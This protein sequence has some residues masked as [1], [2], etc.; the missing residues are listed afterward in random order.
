MEAT[1]INVF[2]NSDQQKRGVWGWSWVILAIAVVYFATARL[3]LLLSVAPSEASG[4][5]PPA[6]I[7]AGAVIIYG[8]RAAAGVFLGAVATY[9][10]SWLD[11]GSVTATIRSVDLVILLSVAVTLQCLVISELVNKYT[12]F[13]AEI[14]SERSTLKFA[15]ILA[16][17]GCLIASTLTNYIF[18]LFDV[19]DIS[20][21]AFSFL[22]WWIGDTIGVV[23]MVP[24]MLAT[25]G[26]RANKYSRQLP[27]AF[28]M[29]LVLSAVF[30][31]F[32]LNQKREERHA[33]QVFQSSVNAMQFELESSFEKS[34]D[35]VHAL[36]SF[37]ASSEFVSDSDFLA[38][39]DHFLD[40]NLHIQ[41]L[42]WIPRVLHEER[43]LFEQFAGGPGGITQLMGDNQLVYATD[44]PVYFPVRYVNPLA[45]N[46]RAF[47]YDVSSNPVVSPAQKQTMA[48]GEPVVSHP[49]RLIQERSEQP[50]V[51]IYLSVENAGEVAGL[52]AM[53]LR[54][55][56]FVESVIARA[57]KITRGL[58]LEIV[59]GQSPAKLLYRTPGWQQALENSEIDTVEREIAFASKRWRVSYAPG[60][61]AFWGVDQTS[62]Y[63]LV[64]GML[65]VAVF[66]A[67]ILSLANRT[68]QISLQVEKRTRELR[69]EV[70]RKEAAQR[71]LRKL[72]QAVEH[73]PNM[74]MVASSQGLIEY[75]NPRFLEVTGFTSDELL[76][77]SVDMLYAQDFSDHYFSRLLANVEPQQPWHGEVHCRKK[78]GQPYWAQT[79][80]ATISDRLGGG[81]G[82]VVLMQD[83]TE[84]RFIQEKINYQ[85]RHDLLTG[86]FNRYEF[87]RELQ[88]LLEDVQVSGATHVFCFCDL[89]QFKLVNDTSGHEAG[90]ALL[91]R[92]ALLLQE[93]FRQ[94]DIIARLGG[95]EFGVLMENCDLAAAQKAAENV[96]AR[97]ESL[98]FSWG[99]EL[100]SI[101]VSIGIVPIDEENCDFTSILKCADSACYAA[102]D[103]GRN[104]V[105]VYTPGD[106]KVAQREGDIAWLT[107]INASLEYDRFELYGQLIV[108]VSDPGLRPHVEVLLRMRHD[109]KLVN[110]GTFL[111]SAERYG[112]A[113][114]I[115][116]WVIDTLFARLREPGKGLDGVGALSV[117]LS[118]HSIG[119][120]KLLE[121]ICHEFSGNGL[122]AKRINFE[123]TETAAISNMA[124]AH[125]FFEQVAAFGSGFCLDDFGSGLSSFAYLKTLPVD[126][127]KIDGMFIRDMA[128]DNVVFAMVKSI[129]EVGQLM[130]KR[131]VAE[132]VETE[133]IFDLVRQVGIDYAQGFCISTP[134]P[135]D[136]A[137]DEARNWCGGWTSQAAASGD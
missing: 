2:K 72:S 46:E 91:K 107:E 100:H 79:A 3:S 114:K 112:L 52:V 103:A 133:E 89:D 24:L 129:N 32:F 124:D 104:R 30:V 1:G 68:K 27:V 122:P 18:L 121:R 54:V 53:V 83:I 42:E 66:G 50:G 70:G 25:L 123:I 12:N 23:T 97:I 105:H 78:D 35:I 77:A 38:F 45:G 29:L 44:K 5:W 81:S 90:D 85:A 33:S 95:D 64:A 110:P 63:L 7:A 15:F 80:I 125:R 8:R 111:P 69:E 102:K 49:I 135:L 120:E 34:L 119:N 137:L 93:S 13:G 59:N 40:R 19:I 84:Q 57:P 22:V 131:T 74:V 36:R 21:F 31:L 132:F 55:E 101:G 116:Q 6:G 86:L 115:D 113:T 62:T 136:E 4:V 128:R 88:R 47:G 60:V 9:L 108:P 75:V 118:G 126:V 11:T 127:I 58:Q 99:D 51:V 37:F 130:G 28:A 82:V 73:S 48:S 17:L 43:A 92:L 87:E 96:R 117:N 109:D 65:F 39:T 67:W 61:T 20:E 56:D 26:T 10:L 134:K 71:E 14:I 98:R 76:G 106:E 16:P 94:S 41:A